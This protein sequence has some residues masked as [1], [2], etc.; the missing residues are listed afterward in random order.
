MTE[1]DIDRLCARTKPI[2]PG[3]PFLI[4]N[5]TAGPPQP[6]DGYTRIVTPRG[7]VARPEDAFPESCCEGAP[8]KDTA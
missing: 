2:P 7:P 4:F 8:S 3:E 5:P 1:D 6:L